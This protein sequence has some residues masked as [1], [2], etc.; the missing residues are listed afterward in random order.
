MTKA[1]DINQSGFALIE[2]FL[3]LV[4]I[5]VISGVGW[6]ALH[7]KHQTDKIL[8]QADQVS[9]STSVSNSKSSANNFFT[10][11]QWGVKGPG[12]SKVT[13][14]YEI[15]SDNGIPE[16]NFTS[17]ELVAK[18]G[19]DCIDGA[20]SI[21]RY[22]GSD[23]IY[24]ESG[25]DS[26]LVS[27]AAVDGKIGKFTKVGDYYYMFRSVQSPCADPDKIGNLES[28]TIDAVRTLTDNLSAV[29]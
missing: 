13:L 10:I 20:G 15:A 4:I 29:Q 19:S 23:T 17:K 14:Q 24:D 12:G 6:Y 26:E 22:K 21:L 9:K 16:A 27:Q 2:A 11:S 1:K 7:T 28:D 5:A 18:G 8:S 3:I 25:L